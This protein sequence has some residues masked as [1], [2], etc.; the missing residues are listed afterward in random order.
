MLDTAASSY[1]CL[2]PIL[3][4]RKDGQLA[5]IKRK[6]ELPVHSRHALPHLDN[7]MST[8]PDKIAL[9]QHACCALISAHATIFHVSPLARCLDPAYV[10]L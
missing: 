1:A 8:K 9:V 4:E 3:A 10:H 5:M 6:T 2:P 7:K